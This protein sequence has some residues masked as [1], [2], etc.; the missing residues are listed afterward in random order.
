MKRVGIFYHDICRDKDIAWLLEGRL[1]NFPQALKEEGILGQPNIFWYESTATPHALL[2]QV[3][4][5]NMIEQV[6]RTEYYQTAL[7]SSGGTV[8]AAEKIY[9]GE[10]DSAFVFTGSADHHAGRER[11]WGGCHFNG[12]ALAIVDV[13]Q[14]F[15]A[16][17]FAILDTDHHHGDGTRDIFKDDADVLHLCFCGT[18]RIVGGGTKI[19]IGIPYHISDKEYLDRVKTEFVPRAEEFK[20]EMIF[21]EFGYDNTRGDYGDIGLTPDCHIGIAKIATEVANRVC[22]G[23]L[24]V[25]LCGGSSPDTARYCIPR[26]IRCLEEEA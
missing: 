23:K 26:I 10:I 24:V 16:R 22:Q 18:D 7:Y 19:D 1:I 11:F 21:W 2:R 9:Q 25:I 13:R 3:H 14:R 15:G 5:E 8:L 6:K 12:A 20:P 17:R 4:T